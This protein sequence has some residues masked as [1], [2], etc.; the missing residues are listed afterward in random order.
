M[1]VDQVRDG[2]VGNFRNG[3]CNILGVGQWGI[4]H[5]N[6]GV[7][8]HE[9]GLITIV[10]NH[11]QGLSEILNAI[12]LRWVDRGSFR[13]FGYWKMLA[14]SDAEW[15]DTRA[16]RVGLSRLAWD[17]LVRARPGWG[18]CGKCFKT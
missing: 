16:V 1:A 13:G 9:H 12:T 14:D 5:N 11:V 15:R 4:Y 2:L 18:N 3:L 17:V 7:I 6:S 10:S 8:D